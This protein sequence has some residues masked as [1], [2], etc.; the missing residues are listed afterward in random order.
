MSASKRRRVAAHTWVVVID[1]FRR[2][3]GVG[4]R[5]ISSDKSSADRPLPHSQVFFL[6]AGDF[7]RE[8]ADLVVAS[9]LERRKT[10]AVSDT[11][12]A[13]QT[14]APKNA[15]A[16][17]SNWGIYFQKLRAPQER[18]IPDKEVLADE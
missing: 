7:G 13:A 12:G 8:P 18:L 1:S 2:T 4:G 10:F 11:Y 17:M 5:S 9:N 6:L 14:D 3:K 15:S 16:S